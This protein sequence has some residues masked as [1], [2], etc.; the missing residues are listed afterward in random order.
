MNDKMKRFVNWKTV[1]ALMLLA[2]CIIMMCMGCKKRDEWYK[3]EGMTFG[4]TY[5]ISYQYKMRKDSVV[6][7]QLEK[8]DMAL[9]LFNDSSTLARLN[10][11]EMVKIDSL[12]LAVFEKGMAV[13]KA[14]DGCFDMTVA[15]LVNLWGFGIDLRHPIDFDS[16][17]RSADSLLQV[18][19]YEKCDLI[20][21]GDSM[22]LIGC[23]VDAAAIAKGFACDVV[24]AALKECG[25]E[26][27]CVEIGGEVVVGGH[28]PHGKEWRIGINRPEEESGMDV[29]DVL[30]LTNCGMATSGNYRNFYKMGAMKISHT[31]DPR[32]GI[33]AVN[34]LKSATIVADECMTADAWATACMVAGLEESVK[35]MKAH[36]ELKA[37][38][39]TKEK[40]G[41]KMTIV[42]NGVVTEKELSH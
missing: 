26:N 5:H 4:T 17:K 23:S 31:I 22:R 35:W 19:G 20:I 12:F 21:E 40:E 11:G 8:I 28:N 37:Y 42:E 38:L 7:V 25:C 9:S 13:S 6:N 10:R 41:F 29:E 14:T 3:M 32:K 30:N 16:I 27:Y 39:I 15:P 18:V 34:N 2:L 36:K 33:P 24:A 1:S